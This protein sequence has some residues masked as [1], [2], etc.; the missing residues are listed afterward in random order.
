MWPQDLRFAH[1]PKTVELNGNHSLIVG[2]V[3][4]GRGIIAIPTPLATSR[5]L[6]RKLGKAQPILYVKT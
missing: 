1:A 2:A 4:H 3:Q 6:R 5:Q